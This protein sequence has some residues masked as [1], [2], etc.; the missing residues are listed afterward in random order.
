MTVSQTFFWLK[1]VS[2]FPLILSIIFNKNLWK[3]EA[4]IIPSGGHTLADNYHFISLIFYCC[5]SAA[6]NLLHFTNFMVKYLNSRQE[7][8]TIYTGFAKAFYT[9]NHKILPSLNV[10]ISLVTWLGSY[11]S[12]LQ[13]L[14]WWSISP[15][16]DVPQ[17]SI[18]CILL[19]LFLINFDTCLWLLYDAD[20][21]RLPAIWLPMDY[22]SLQ[23]NLDAGSLVTANATSPK[24]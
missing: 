4:F 8:H 20:L 11:L 5:Q 19:L 17:G 23:S 6:S 3:K 21:K 16:S 2:S 7:V 15:F 18:L 1:L 9:V 22:A 12:N 13:R 14:F 24:F 10:P